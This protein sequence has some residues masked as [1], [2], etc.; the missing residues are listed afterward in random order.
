MGVF[1]EG[2]YRVQPIYVDDLAQAAAQKVNKIM[3]RSLRPLA[4]RRSPTG[5][6]LPE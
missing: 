4:R 1:G 2:D 3:T 6:W 5:S